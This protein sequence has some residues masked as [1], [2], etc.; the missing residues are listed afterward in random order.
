MPKTF[1]GY[2]PIEAPTFDIESPD[3]ERTLTVRCV[4]M[5]PGSRFLDFLAKVDD[6]DPRSMSKA[7]EDLLRTAV[8]P[9]AWDEFKA[10]IDQPEN[11]IGMEMLAEI[12]GYLGE[13]YARRPTAPS[14]PSSAT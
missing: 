9:D 11:G 3:G 13:L 2:V 7:V 1:K 10:F 8:R 4:G 6:E 12:T 14:E 5:L